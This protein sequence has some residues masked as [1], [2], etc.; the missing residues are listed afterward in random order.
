[1]VRPVCKTL[2]ITAACLIAAA[3]LRHHSAASPLTTTQEL[4]RCLTLLRAASARSAPGHAPK[5]QAFG[6]HER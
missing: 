6:V 2:V 3:K 4:N 5:R 1:M